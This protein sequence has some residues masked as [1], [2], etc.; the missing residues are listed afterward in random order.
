MKRFFKLSLIGFSTFSFAGVLIG[1]DNNFNKPNLPP[2]KEKPPVIKDIF[3]YE[4]LKKKIITEIKEYDE[5]IKEIKNSKNDYE[6]KK[7]YQVELNQTQAEQFLIVA[8][9]NNCEYQILLCQKENNFTE[10]QKQQATKLLEKQINNLNSVWNLL[11]EIKNSDFDQKDLEQ[12]KTKIKKIK[13][14]L[15]GIKNH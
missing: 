1:C 13:T 10:E 11:S 14:I 6:I 4:K 9:L 7:D 12:I 5:I 15:D 3:Y 2:A 8:E